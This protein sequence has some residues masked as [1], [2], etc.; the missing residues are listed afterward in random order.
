MIYQNQLPDAIE[1]VRKFP[2]QSFILNHI[3]KPVISEGIND[4][5]IKGIK[6]LSESSN[7]Y[8]KL[9]GMVTETLNFEWKKDDFRPFIDVI[10]TSFGTERVMFGS[11][12]P[13]C[14]LAGEYEDV[15]E[16][17]EEYISTFSLNEQERILGKNAEKIYGL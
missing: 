4:F 15:L 11:D 6:T 10:I 3:A 2:H 14:L 13:V 7:V 8:C 5:W 9:S 1:L 16:I 12:W 17:V